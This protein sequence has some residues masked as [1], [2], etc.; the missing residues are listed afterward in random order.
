MA[1]LH[2][3]AAC[4]ALLAAGAIA[5]AWGEVVINESSEILFAAYVPCAN[6][7]AGEVVSLSGPLHVLITYT[8]NGN[9]VSGKTHFQPQGLFGT[10]QVTGDAYHGVGVTQSEFSG[11]LENGQFNQT[12]LNNF[13]IIGQGPGNNFAIH[14]NF[15]L[16]IN[17]NGELSTYHDNFSADC[18]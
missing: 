13:R 4:G 17:A 8:V 3:C 14:E 15:H 5:P 7:G 2:I 10:G 12:Y 16:T 11:S 6:K 18:K 9:H 1:K